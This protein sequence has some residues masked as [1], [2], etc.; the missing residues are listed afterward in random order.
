M[1][2]NNNLSE[3]N[4]H[5]QSFSSK[6]SSSSKDKNN[7]TDQVI[8]EQPV[9]MINLKKA[10][11]SIFSQVGKAKTSEKPTAF[12]STQMQIQVQEK[13][14][15]QVLDIFNRTQIKLKAFKIQLYLYIQAN[16]DFFHDNVNKTLFAVIY[17]RGIA[18]D[19]IKSIAIKIIK[20]L[21]A[22]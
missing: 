18:F 6:D 19:W 17:L 5:S 12:N 4:N 11:I 2:S 13:P 1:P 9:A 20:K 3:E 8:R 15:I 10:S 7:S 21:Q 22:Q 14:K 16:P